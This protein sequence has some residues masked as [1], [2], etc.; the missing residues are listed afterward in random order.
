VRLPVPPLSRLK[1]SKTLQPQ[2]VKNES[3]KRVMLSQVSPA[4]SYKG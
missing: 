1:N 4:Q 2:P 3:R